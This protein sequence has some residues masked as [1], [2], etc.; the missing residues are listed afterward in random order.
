[1]EVHLRLDRGQAARGV[2]GEGGLPEA[3]AE[4]GAAVESAVGAGEHEWRVG[5]VGAVFGEQVGQEW[6]QVHGAGAGRGLGRAEFEAPAELVQRAV[7]RVDVDARVGIV[8]V[9]AGPLQAAS[10][11]QRRPV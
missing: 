2:A 6:R 1:M 11:P 8:E 9:G 7:S 3:L 5:V 10:S 4:V